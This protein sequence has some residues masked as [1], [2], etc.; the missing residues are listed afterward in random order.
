MTDATAAVT[1]FFSLATTSPPCTRGGRRRATNTLM[2]GRRQVKH[3][4]AAVSRPRDGEIF[5]RT[6]TRRTSPARLLVVVLHPAYMPDF[7]D[8]LISDI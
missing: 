7:Y 5:V 1:L 4:N 2:Q 6:G 3:A 8:S